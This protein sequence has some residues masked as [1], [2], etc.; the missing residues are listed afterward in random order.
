[1]KCDQN[2]M[3]NVFK[4]IGKLST[5][6]IFESV[7]FAEHYLNFKTQFKGWGLNDSL[8][9][10]SCMI[11][12]L[13]KSVKLSLGLRLKLWIQR[14]VSNLNNPLWFIVEGLNYNYNK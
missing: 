6:N 9:S 5:G 1:M 3:E 7:V 14:N 12:V 8:S 10:S 4:I 2:S 11:A 13:S